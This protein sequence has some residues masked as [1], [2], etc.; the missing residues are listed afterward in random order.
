MSKDTN[1]ALKYDTNFPRLKSIII[2]HPGGK[3]IQEGLLISI[4]ARI[5]QDKAANTESYQVWDTATVKRLR[6]RIVLFTTSFLNMPGEFWGESL[7][8]AVWSFT[9]DWQPVSKLIS[10]LWLT[11]LM[12]ESCF[13]SMR[14]CHTRR[15]VKAL[16]LKSSGLALEVCW[17]AL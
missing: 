15:F 7:A 4:K 14:K 16:S 13:R 17:G 2:I 3:Y 8:P 5:Q 1:A 10:I 12:S 11:G 9:S 6:W